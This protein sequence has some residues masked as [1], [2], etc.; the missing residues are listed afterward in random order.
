MFGEKTKEMSHSVDCR[1][2]LVT[3]FGLVGG[4]EM[5][6]SK[7]DIH[8]IFYVIVIILRSPNSLWVWALYFSRHTMTVREATLVVYFC[9]SCANETP[10]KGS[11]LD[12]KNLL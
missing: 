9:G 6:E 3:A 8:I 11:T 5:N 12:G 1:I 2:A 10:K 7:Y 4:Q